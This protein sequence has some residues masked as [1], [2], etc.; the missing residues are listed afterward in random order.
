VFQ[1]VGLGDAYRAAREDPDW[2]SLRDQITSIDTRLIEL[3]SRLTGKSRNCCWEQVRGLANRYR[4]LLDA[5]DDDSAALALQ[6]L[7]R[8]LEAGADEE[9]TWARIQLAMETRRRLTDVEGRMLERLHQTF[10][11][12]QALAVIHA[13]AELAREFVSAD[14]LS[15]FVQ[16]LR[17]ITLGIPTPP[18]PCASLPRSRNGQV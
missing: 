16:R 10:T 8:L 2:L 5:D 3:H 9:N 17:L 4:V 18:R 11:V 1:R 7:L 14:R 12:E 6:D 15:E 13:I